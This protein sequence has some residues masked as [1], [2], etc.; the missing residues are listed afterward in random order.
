MKIL[1][2]SSFKQTSTDALNVVQDFLCTAEKLTL[3]NLIHHIARSTACSIQGV[4]ESEKGV[5]EKIKERRFRWN[6]RRYRKF[7]TINKQMSSEIVDY[8]QTND[9]ENNLL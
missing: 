7:F 5:E 4:L 2:T 6:K 9:K 8:S 3:K 1:C